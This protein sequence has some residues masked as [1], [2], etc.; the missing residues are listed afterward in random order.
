MLAALVDSIRDEIWYSDA[1]GRFTLVNPSGKHKFGLEADSVTDVRRLAGRIEVLRTDGTPRPVEEAPPLRA[2]RGEVVS[3]QE[4]V[5]RTPATGE[6]Q[7]RQVSASPVHD[8]SGNIIGSV[9]VVRDITE[10]KRVEEALRES[11]EQFRRAIEEAPIPVFMHDEDGKVLQVSRAWTELTGYRLSELPTLD[12]WLDTI[13]A[14]G[15]DAV[16]DHV[17][18]LFACNGPL[19]N[20]EF[21]IRTRDGQIRHLSF[22]ASSPGTLAGGRRYVV[23]MGV[24]VTERRQ[25][26][27]ELRRTR[28]E[29]ELRVRQRTEELQLANLQLSRENQERMHT[30]HSLRLE[31]ARLDALLCLSQMSDAP[32]GEIS[33]F[34]LERAI[35]LTRSKIGFVGFL[36]EDE[37]VYTLHSVSRD[38]LKECNVAGNPVQWMVEDAGIWANAIRE[39]RSVLINDYHA[40]LPD[41][42]GLPAGHLPIERFMVVP[43]FDEGK[44]T[45]LGGVANKDSDYDASD[46]RQV[47]L[48]VSGMYSC[49]QR[50]R[51]RAELQKAH[52][53]LEERVRQ[54]TAELSAAKIAAEA[55]NQAKS[56]FLAN[57]SHEL[58]TPMNAILGLINVALSK[59]D[60][61][62]VQDC[63]G[64]A[65]ESADLLLTLLN[66]LLDSAKVESG[67]VELELVP[68]SLRRM[69]DQITRVLAARASEKGLTFYCRIPDEAPDAVIGDRMRLQQIL[70]NLA[71]NAIK[72]TEQGEVAVGLHAL[73]HDGQVSLEFAV[74]DTG[75]GIPPLQQKQLFEP[76][77]QADSFMTR[78]FG[79]TGLGLF[80]SKNL[81]EKMGGR[82]WAESETGKGSTFHFSLRLP[83]AK[84][85]PPDFGVP[86]IPPAAACRQLRLLLVEDNPANQKLATYI[87]QDRGHVVEIAGD[88]HEALRLTERNRYDLILMD[89]QMPGMTGLEATA[90]IR[91]RESGGSRVPIVAMTAH[92]MRDDRERCL[93]AG[94][95]GYLSKP[96]D[97]CEMINLVESL[98]SGVQ[99]VAQVLETTIDQAHDSPETAVAAFNPDEALTRCFNSGRMVRKMMQYFL[100]ETDS[101]F[102]QMR[103]ALDRGDLDEVGKLGHRMKGTVVFLAAHPAEEAA[104]QVE[105]FCKSGGGSRSDA[106]DAVNALEH[107]CLALKAALD[108]FYQ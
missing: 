99:P 4:E 16:R 44:I 84:T 67:K 5:V 12:A 28:D 59:A 26:E 37:S 42:K 36:N 79:G 39:R 49:I 97:A 83:L 31:E 23:S 1:A 105:R 43:I 15:A 29:L 60:H 72:F 52:D 40:P 51:S 63:L 76:F 88:G 45:V 73:S 101:L 62:A 58:R 19:L 47:A 55:A 95:D 56:Q 38:V 8:G 78:R 74:R 61:P 87:L 80:I 89:I 57:M 20:M 41:K 86:A 102:P 22:S 104:L 10:L 85:L 93:A 3:T 92:A 90:A 82:I 27:E 30:E 9:S 17:R 65:R 34:T 94:M 24:D 7:Y 25:A 103:A 108:K 100:E 11:R 106:E 53:D 75:I 2:L 18:Q 64:T 66:D 91:K 69:L 98:S 96:F 21:P 35:A 68:F 71:G 13:S 107:E 50:N 33:N 48:L 81:V 77:A 14:E 54:R 6:L 32:H 46:E 70:L